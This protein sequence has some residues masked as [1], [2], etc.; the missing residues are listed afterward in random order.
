VLAI[1]ALQACASGESATQAKKA[2]VQAIKTVAAQLGNT[3]ALCCKCQRQSAVI[4]AYLGGSLLQ[5]LQ[6]LAEQ[7]TTPALNGLS[8]EEGR[9]LAF[10]RQTLAR[11]ANEARPQTG[12][13]AAHGS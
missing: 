9:V 6:A 7:N 13:M 1:Q 12:A 10:L 11:E 4:E 5:M 3:P 8:P 2:V